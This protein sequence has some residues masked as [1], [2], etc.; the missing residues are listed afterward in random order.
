MTEIELTKKSQAERLIIADTLMASV[1]EEM[2][3]GIIEDED[4]IQMAV[5]IQVSTNRIVW[6]RNKRN[7]KNVK[8]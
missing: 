3:Q 4:L 2:V 1:W 5:L 8:A 7:N 6:L